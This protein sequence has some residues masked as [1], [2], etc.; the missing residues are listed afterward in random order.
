[1]T[2]DVDNQEVKSPAER[3]MRSAA[4]RSLLQSYSVEVTSIDASSITV[5]GQSLPAGTEV[6]IASL[7]K[8]TPELLIAAAV[9]LRRLGLTPV[10]HIVARNIANAATLKSLLQGLAEQAG[11]D[12]ALVLGGDRDLPAGGFDESL[13]LLET[14]HFNHFNIC[15]LYLSCYPE[16]HPR[17]PLETLINA[18]ITKLAAAQRFGMDVTLVSQFCF[19]AEPVLEYARTIRSRGVTVPYRVGVAGP[20]SRARLMKFAIMCGIGPSLRVLREREQMAS[21]MLSGATPQDMLE[22][23]ATAQAREPDLGICSVHFFTFGSL[24]KTVEFVRAATWTG[25]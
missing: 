24:A 8:D 9:K 14:G 10:P 19:A 1:L 22:E 6:F 23:I 21:N 20:A 7:P 2:A 18:R 5:A 17:I 15:K 25:A 3:S 16:G 13:Q 12:R 4:L 11:V